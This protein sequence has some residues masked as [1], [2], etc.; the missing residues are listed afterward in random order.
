MAAFFQPADLTNPYLPAQVCAAL[1]KPHGDH[2]T[3]YQADLMF[4]ELGFRP[5]LAEIFMVSLAG[6]T[7]FP[8]PEEEIRAVSFTIKD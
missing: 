6:N 8:H 5:V 3:G 4:Q 1:S 2:M 7:F